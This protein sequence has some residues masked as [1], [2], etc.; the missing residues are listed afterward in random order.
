MRIRKP[1]A[2]LALSLALALSALSLTGCG[3]IAYT[4][5]HGFSTPPESEFGFGPRT[6]QIGGYVATIEPEAPLRTGAMQRLRFRLR[7]AAGAPVVGARVTIDGGMPQHGHGLPTQPRVTGEPA[8][9]VYE[10]DGLRFNMG[11]W[12]ELR[13]VFE[14][15]GL[16]DRVIFNVRL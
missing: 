9:G 7:D 16:A 4:L 10:V 6:S 15:S 5:Q 13:F 1:V 12:W 8:D 14:R 2:A 3:M 11:G